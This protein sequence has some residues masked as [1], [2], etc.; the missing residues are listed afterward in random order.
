MLKHVLVLGL[1]LGA[2]VHAQ[3]NETFTET[4]CFNMPAMLKGGMTKI[5]ATFSVD[6]IKYQAQT[7]EVVALE[8]LGSK[9]LRGANDGIFFANPYGDR[10]KLIGGKL[11]LEDEVI[12]S[13]RYIVS[14]A[15]FIT[16]LRNI[17]NDRYTKDD[18]N[19]TA[20]WSGVPPDRPL[21]RFEDGETLLAEIVGKKCK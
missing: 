4:Y 11:T 21:L 9:I 1:V 7:R 14:G 10:R 17:S 8:V 19:E 15:T 16:S 18:N 6:R 12:V 2:T 20:M 5:R 3:A 13:G